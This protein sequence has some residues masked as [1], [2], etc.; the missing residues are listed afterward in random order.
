MSS[1]SIIRLAGKGDIDAANVHAYPEDNVARIVDHLDGDDSVLVFG[2]GY[3]HAEGVVTP[4]EFQNNL[5]SLP[6]EMQQ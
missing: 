5:T 2:S 6:L 3:P 4:A 1:A